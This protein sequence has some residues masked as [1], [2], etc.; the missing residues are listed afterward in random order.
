MDLGYPASTPLNETQ[1]WYE[2][3]EFADTPEDMERFFPR[4]RFPLTGETYFT[5][6]TYYWYRRNFFELLEQSNA[7]TYN[8][9][10][11]GTL[12]GEGIECLDL[13]TFL[14]MKDDG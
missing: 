12:F 7:K 14:R 4:F 1:T 11:G 10:G 6:P 2:L 13:D 3:H 8:C 5:D 9:T